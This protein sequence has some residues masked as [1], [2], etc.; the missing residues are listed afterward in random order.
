MKKVMSLL[1][2]VVVIFAAPALT[3]TATEPP[4]LSGNLTWDIENINY[5]LT[6]TA[7]IYA[8]NISAAA[9]NW[10]YTGHGYNRLWPNTRTYSQTY[11]AI[12]LYG[13][14]RV[15]G[16]NGY[17]EFWNDSQA[18]PSSNYRYCRIYLNGNYTMGGTNNGLKNAVVA[19]EMGHVWGLNENNSNVNSIMCQAGSGRAV[20][21]VQRVDNNA[22]N[23]KHP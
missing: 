9:N 2:V 4:L 21:T 16:N 3:A 1:L 10:V 18:S 14:N 11:S 7:T 6:G 5:F 23:R 17:T 13:Y 8:T 19:H 15:D 20:N 22:F 12:D